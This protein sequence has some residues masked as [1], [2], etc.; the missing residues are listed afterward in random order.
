[1]LECAWTQDHTRKHGVMGSGVKVCFYGLEPPSPCCRDRCQK[2]HRTI[3]LRSG[4]L[5]SHIKACASCRD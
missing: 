2:P 5:R 3:P 4:K 1:M